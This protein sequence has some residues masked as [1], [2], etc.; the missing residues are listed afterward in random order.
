MQ[1]SYEQQFVSANQQALNEAVQRYKA[2]YAKELSQ[3]P[4]L[5]RTASASP[6]LPGRPA[7]PGAPTGPGGISSPSP[8]RS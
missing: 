5:L 8:T 6:N 4:A 7:K 1:A 2:A 3:L